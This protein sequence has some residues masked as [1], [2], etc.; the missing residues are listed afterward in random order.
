VLSK[1][2]R[3]SPQGPEAVALLDHDDASALENELLEFDLSG[4]AISAM[5]TSSDQSSAGEA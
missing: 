2:D 3:P 4:G 5:E 1:Y